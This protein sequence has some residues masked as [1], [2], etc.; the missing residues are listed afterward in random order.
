MNS[1][2][3]FLTGA[4][5]GGG[6]FRNTPDN[7]R[8]TD[9]FELLL[10]LGTNP[11]KLKG[12]NLQNMF[13]DGVPVEDGQ[14]NSSFTD[15][16]VDMFGGDPTTLE[17]IKLRLGQSGGAVNVGLGVGNTY[18]NG[19][20]GD[21]RTAAITQT[22][23]DFIDLR[24]VVQQLF[25]QTKSGVFGTTA[26]LEIELRPSG[27]STWINPL[28]SVDAPQFI[29]NGFASGFNHFIYVTREKWFNN[30]TQN[31]WSV[32]NPGKLPI[33]GKTTSAYIKE[34]RIAVPNEGAYANKS[35]Q[36]RVRLIERDYVVSGNNGENEDRRTITW[37]SIAGVSSAQFGG[38]E[39]W[40][41]L[42]HAL[43][44]GKATDQ[45]NGLPEIT[46]IYDIGKYLVPPSSVWD[47]V[48]RVYTGSAWD[49]ATTVNAWTTDP[50]W[51]IKGLIED[52]LS[53]ISAL[54]PGSTLNKWD[55]LE[56]S[57]WFS[58]LVPDGVGGT[59]PRYSAHWYLE[60]GMQVHE[61]VNYLAGAVGSFCWD[62]GDGKWRM[63][64]E[65]PENSQLIFTKENIVGEFVYSHTDFDQRL[66]DITGV[67]RNAENNYAEDRVR[68]YDQASIDD[69]G[70][71]HTSFALV[72]CDNRQEA[73]RR[74]YLRMLTS[75][76][77]TRMVSFTTNR[78]G[79]TLEP[80]SVI[81]VADGD[82]LAD[83]DLRTT[84][85]V[86][87]VATDRTW[88]R[89]RDPIHLEVGVAYEIE[90]T[91]PNPNYNPE[92][93][94]QPTNADWRKPTINVTRTVVNT[95]GQRGAVYTIYLNTALPTSVPEFAPISL[96]AT[97]LPS[98]PKQYRVLSVAPQEGEL[99]AISAVE[100]YTQKWVLSDAITEAA[101]NGQVS[102][103][104]VPAP[105]APTAGVFSTYT[106]ES[107]YG[108]R[109][110]LQANW[111]RP[112][113]YLVSKYRIETSY[114]GG[115][116][117]NQ[118]ITTDTYFEIPDPQRGYYAIQIFS[119]DRRGGESPALGATYHQDTDAL[120]APSVT[121]T[122]GAISVP[123]NSSGVVASWTGVG[124]SFILSNAL[125]PV[126]TGVTYSV[127]G[128]TGG[129]SVTIDAAG[130]YA[131][132]GLTSNF[133][134]ATLRA[135][136]E[137][138]TFDQILS[139]SKSV[140][141][142][143]GTSGA[144]SAIVYLYQRAVS[145]PA[146]PTGTFTYTFASG[147]LT[148]GTLGSWTTTIPA[149]NGNQLWVIAATASAIGAT[150]T[151]LAT[152]FSAPVVLASNGTSGTSG[153]NSASVFLYKRSATVPTVPASTLTYTF[154]TASLA[155]TLEGWTQTVPA[156]ADPLYV[157]TAT[158]V[159]S[160]TTDTILTSEWAAP[161]VM[162]QN[163]ASGTSG[164]S[165]AV[166]YLYQRAVS[167][168][169]APTGTFTFTFATGALTG[170]TPGAWTTT[171][172]ANNGNPLWVIAA[173]A[174]GTGTT[175]TIPAAEFSS[176]VI[177][178][179]NGADG[180]AGLNTAS[181]FLYQRAASV[182][183]V[184]T[185]TLTYT[186]ATAALSGTLG[187]WSQTIPAGTD[188]LYVTTA[189]AASNA[190]TDTIANT[191]WAAV[192]V[193]AQNGS[194]G[195]P[196]AAASSAH[197]TNDPIQ[198]QA[199]ATGVVTSYTGAT[200]EFKVFAGTTDI[201]SN[202]T[203]STVANP[204]L[205][206]IGYV[207]RTYTVTGGFDAN[208]DTASVTIRAT[209]SGAY[210]GVTFDRVLTLSKSKGGYAIVTSL[211]A[212]DST[213]GPLVFNDTDNKLYRWD[214]AAWTTAV[215]AADV[216]GQLIDTQIQAVSASKIAG[217]LANSQ[218]EAV[219]AAKVTGQLSD[220]QLAAI[221]AAKLT[222]QIVGTQ[223]TDGAVTTAKVAAGAI[224]AGQIAADTITAANI[225]A[226]AVTASELAAGSVIAGKV[227]AG[228]ISATE[229]AANSVVAGKI[230]ANAVSANE[231]AANAVRVQHLLVAP[232]NL[233]PDPQFRDQNLWIQDDEAAGV[234]DG[235]L[236][237]TSVGWF[238]EE[239]ANPQS[240][241]VPA[242]MG[243]RWIQLWSGRSGQTNS[244][245]FV[246]YAANGLNNKFNVYS[247]QVL[248]LKAA[249][250]NASNQSVF[251]AVQFFNSSDSYLGEL[252]VG[253]VANAVNLEAA[254]IT[255]PNNSA[256]GRVVIYNN[257]G[258]TYFGRAYVSNISIRDTA[259]ATAIID[260]SIIAGKIAANAIT[261]DKI[262]AGAVTAAKVAASNV[263]TLS[264]QINDAVIT[265]AKIGDL[266]VNTL[267]I[268][269]NAVTV[270][271]SAFSAGDVTLPMSGAWQDIQSITISTDG[272]PMIILAQASIFGDGGA[273]V[274]VPRILRNGAEIRLGTGR[275][276]ND[277]VASDAILMIAD[278][279]SSGTHTYTFQARY[280]SG[281][282]AGI[283]TNRF[284][285]ALNTKK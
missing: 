110:V 190:A 47:P 216:A 19:A 28:L 119:V 148:G 225:A 253:V 171:I 273:A 166:A 117:Q 229:L 34:L 60:Q 198:L 91:I 97:N 187:S 152:E 23:C 85:R 168:P 262:E 279:P 233:N 124:G 17:P 184:P 144:S 274:S 95:A 83:T 281:S 9:T 201:S 158:A 81:S 107:S 56:A 283:A 232:N 238:T 111:E 55:V 75:M 43:I 210:V 160:A 138:L 203:L 217:L 7:L 231:I 202:F 104:S 270:G 127:Q 53:G 185:S 208:E 221:S 87:E 6:S 50:A 90:F 112:A 139:V 284:L 260:G 280:A 78:Q 41:G 272:S 257:G 20:P 35:W 244:G 223:I 122:N 72:G 267:K 250:W 65:R 219:A 11:M 173:T 29:A 205:I 48:T 54:A 70:R 134:Q 146:A 191:E 80:L 186:F 101:I 126:T 14:G 177:L 266:Q 118:G 25:S 200:G 275:S 88:V 106:F 96:K 163:G 196:G 261:A 174:S 234:G 103:R 98:L 10:G 64:V 176:P 26:T 69:T 128:T 45:I 105:V 256:Y 141:G 155:G 230:A 282:Y 27:S 276:G 132:S 255:P 92:P 137:G 68:V 143:S 3:I 77:E 102:D 263:I 133:G 136:W 147:A 140:A 123:A 131:V 57:K 67:F 100:I 153:L 151:I 242:I 149:N 169:A 18:T 204:Q 108:T 5:G 82:L 120:I 227:A 251:V 33:T 86:V 73:L 58:E 218:I 130:V 264:A 188:P 178:V 192:R 142:A 268:A 199:F 172:P 1:K 278:T 156:G 129:L 162:A 271:V 206:T 235:K 46:G 258:S 4:K 51:Q 213:T 21:W 161:T 154:T 222:G 135:T 32:S 109:T 116:W 15:L 115:P 24:F 285:F 59:H 16:F 157:I 243:N 31:V 89:V 79:F 52:S 62:E 195:A 93:T 248:E 49:G 265:N 99:V 247:G 245:R 40:R 252:R 259:G 226:G 193:L 182:P 39:G 37:E 236:D 121:L 165:N 277:A 76:N 220:A 179:S 8:S 214:G 170:G 113:G 74:T 84:G 239:F 125:G 215:P 249:I 167:A 181:I 94:T 30:G 66:N 63:K 13:V 237:S 240:L 246:L 254:Q 61:L 180:T 114:N 22:G 44:Y 38:T 241:G 209:G 36:V 175:D 211:P 207:N 194:A 164:V 42:S 12:D 189:T 150:D 197:L 145:A 159:S 224:T 269:G 228:A 212:N 2:D 71:R 183:A